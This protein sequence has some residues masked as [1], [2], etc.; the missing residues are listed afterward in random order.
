MIYKIAFLSFF[1][2]RPLRPLRFNK[3]TFRANQIILLYNLKYYPIDKANG[4]KQLT[5]LNS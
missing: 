2:L 1:P 5:R 3:K 4:I